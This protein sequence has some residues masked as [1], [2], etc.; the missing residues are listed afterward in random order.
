MRDVIEG[1]ILVVLACVVSLRAVPVQADTLPG[2]L[3]D[4][5]VSLLYSRPTGHVAIYSN[6]D[7]VE[8]GLDGLR[9]LS[10]SEQMNPENA[11]L[12]S[13]GEYPIQTAG[14]LQL[15]F[16]SFDPDNTDPDFV[17]GHGWNLGKILDPG[18]DEGFLL[19]D[20][21]IEYSLW[22]QN[23]GIAEGDLLYGVAGDADL[24]GD[25]D[26]AD[27]QTAIAQ[28]TGAQLEPIDGILW[29]DAD[30]DLDGD[31]DTAD[32][33]DVIANWTG[34][35]QPMSPEGQSLLVPEPM[36]ISLLALGAVGLLRRKR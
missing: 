8:T 29:V 4:G 21:T 23:E 27:Q 30:F 7:G 26:S 16:I 28:F 35:I 2:A 19:G 32:R 36:T 20:L 24:D 22:G 9:I 31:V 18:L 3:G 14:E 6:L 1:L 33:Q 25:V 12:P 17:V 15:G 11:I 13:E 10:A 5:T 34:A